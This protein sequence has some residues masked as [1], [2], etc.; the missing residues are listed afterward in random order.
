MSDESIKHL[1]KNQSQGVVG[2][3]YY[4]EDGKKRGG[5][6]QPGD[7]VWLTKKDAVA[8]AGAPKSPADNPLTNGALVHEGSEDDPST[9]RP[10]G[11]PDEAPSSSEPE[12]APEPEESPEEP[13]GEGEPEP[14]KQP[15][16]EQLAQE[17]ADAEKAER[18][19][20]AKRKIAEAED[21]QKRDEEAAQRVA[22]P[23]ADLRPDSAK[24]KA[25]AAEEQAAATPP[26]GKGAE[27]K[28]AEAEE[29]GK[30][31]EGQRSSS[32]A[33]ATPTA[34]Q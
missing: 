15:S 33:V 17:E 20:I 13:S 28:A 30:Q 6:V 24:P 3:T 21:K 2:Y 27:E 7:S 9:S 8:T 1:Y 19:E 23:T 18:D 29:Q 14:S 12:P 4:D 31:G 32:E 11:L 26:A 34:Q 22:K 5:A 25:K 16:A 10:I